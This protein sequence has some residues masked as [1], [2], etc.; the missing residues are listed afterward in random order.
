[1]SAQFAAVRNIN[2]KLQKQNAGKKIEL[3]QLKK[4]IWSL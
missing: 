3:K 1:M 2:L 4:N